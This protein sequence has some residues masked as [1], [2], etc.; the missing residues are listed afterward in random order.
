MKWITDR[1]PP[2]EGYYIGCF[3]NIK[4]EFY[5][6]EFLYNPNYTKEITTGVYGWISDD[7]E[8]LSSSE[9]LGWMELPKPLPL[10]T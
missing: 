4:G 9:L 3:K 10:N 8:Y 1:L 5:S 2:E 6:T 7:S